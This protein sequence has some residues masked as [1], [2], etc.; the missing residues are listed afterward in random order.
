MRRFARCLRIG[1]IHAS[2]LIKDIVAEHIVE[3]MAPGLVRISAYIHALSKFEFSGFRIIHV[4]IN[5]ENDVADLLDGSPGGPIRTNPVRNVALTSIAI[6]D[7]RPRSD[8]L[9]QFGW[10]GGGP[11][12]ARG[13]ERLLSASTN[14][15]NTRSGLAGSWTVVRS[16]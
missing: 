6:L 10:N 16:R 3:T 4:E 11:E 15:L 9:L 5:I 7:P 14:H 12:A 13:P 8:L 1:F 2:W